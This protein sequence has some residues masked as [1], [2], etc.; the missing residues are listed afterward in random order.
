VLSAHLHNPPS[1]EPGRVLFPDKAVLVIYDYDNNFGYQIEADFPVPKRVEITPLKEQPDIFSEVE[2]RDAVQVLASDPKYGEPLRRGIAY[3]SPGMPPVITEAAPESL[4]GRIDPF[5]NYVPDHR[6]VSVLLHFRPGSGRESEIGHFLIDLTDRQVSAYGTGGSDFYPAACGGPPASGSCT[7]VGGSAWQALAW[8]ASNPVWRMLVRR[9]S[10]STGDGQ[11]YGSG[12]E[13]ADVFYN[14]R[15]VLKRGGMPVLN[16]FYDS[17]CPNFRDWLYS[18]TC[19]KCTGT[20]TNRAFRVYELP[21]SFRFPPL[22][23]GNREGRA[24]S[25]PPACRGNLKEGVFS[26]PCYRKLCARDW[27]DLGNGLRFANAGT[28]AVTICDDSN[29]SGNFRGV[30]VYEDTDSELVL[31]TECS[32]GWYRY[33]TG[34]RFNRSGILK[35]RFLYGYTDS[36]CVCY[37]RLHNGY[38][39]LH[40]A[41][42]SLGGLVVEETDSPRGGR[43][44]NWQ[45]IRI[46]ARRLRW[47]NRPTRWRVRK[48]STGFTAEIVPSAKDGFHER[49]NTGEGDVWIV[50]ARST[51]MIGNGGSFANITQ[52]VN[53]ERTLNEDLV[54]WY[55]VHLRKRGADT[56]ECPPLG[57]DIYLS[58]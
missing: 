35:P 40:F 12:V 30:G 32:A 31:I 13:I 57:P 8:P 58:G 22:R 3:C 10:A 52:Y 33:I 7:N 56:L 51:E 16:V 1:P 45:P 9:P 44:E 20:D 21:P 36:S 34:W 25:V 42:D 18:E 4:W 28:R 6:M 37:G 49:S 53:G 50:K 27:Y 38:W 5:P 47:P 23:E 26:C 55:G 14:G 43:R 54:V 48:L 17:G 11:S 24:Y 19:F 15:L 39:R 2:F 29:D 46:E 41:L